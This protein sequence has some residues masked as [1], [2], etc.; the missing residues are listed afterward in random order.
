[1]RQQTRGGLW[2]F[3]RCLV[4]L[5]LLAS[6]AAGAGPWQTPA[7]AAV[8]DVLTLTGQTRNLLFVGRG[9][10]HGVGMCQWG[11]RG[12]AIAGQS[13]EQI[14]AAYYPGTSVAPAVPGET[15]VR[16][17]VHYALPQEARIYARHGAWR[18]DAVDGVFPPDGYLQV[19]MSD[20][21]QPPQV[22]VHAPDGHPLAQPG[23]NWPITVHPGDPNARFQLAYPHPASTTYRGSISLVSSGGSVQTVNTVGIEDY[24]RGVVAAEMDPRW[25]HEALRTQLIASRSYA[26]AL[27]RRTARRFY[28]LD[29]TH[30]SQ[31]YGGTVMERPHINELVDRNRGLAVTHHGQVAATYFTSTC[32]GWTENIE[33]VWSGGSPLA[34]L[35][36]IRDVDVLGQPYDAASPYSNWD[37]GPVSIA[38]LDHALNTDPDTRVGQLQELDFSRR[39]RSGRLTHV[40]L[41][42][43]EGERTVG[44]SVF[45][46]SLANYGPDDAD[47]LWSANFRLLW[48][49]A[50][51]VNGGQPYAGQPRQPQPPT[52]QYDL[53]RTASIPHNPALGGTYF[54]ETGH[55]VTGKFLTIFEARGGVEIFGFPRTES[56]I[57]D[58]ITV[59]YFQRARLELHPDKL[60]TPYEVQSTLIGDILTKE[61][62]SVFLKAEPRPN[63]DSYRY[64]PE[65]G[66]AVQF[67][68]KRFYDDRDGLTILGY[69]ISNELQ[70]D[71]VAVQYFQRG[72]LEYHPDRP[73]P[74]VLG[75]LGDEWLRAKLWL[76]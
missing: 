59:Q 69:P 21:G 60:G 28:D 36:G 17:R 75:L 34:Y 62:G 9:Y 1:M 19:R 51:A 38:Q 12:R 29:D 70:E 18:I 31:N 25:P 42:G 15:A 14:L 45:L 10:G 76:K 20:A 74:I 24:L 23:L 73:Q 57:E 2:L 58:G 71:G 26:Y 7:A 8:Q 66:Y 5:A 4:V 11:A 41:R 6:I 56:F 65:T 40:R 27:S 54:S 64:F 49:D 37:I 16:I 52:P 3:G 61:R 44:V 63:S 53:S 39:T 46:N 13:A 47:Q 32:S 30:S 33:D 22:S 68:F 67:G 35:R 72:R 48:T 50:P 43:S 55:H